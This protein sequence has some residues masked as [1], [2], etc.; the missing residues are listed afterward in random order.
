MHSARSFPRSAVAS[1]FLVAWATASR[2]DHDPVVRAQ[3]ER[4][5]TISRVSPAVVCVYDE[6]QRGGGS[7]VLIDREGHGLTN[8]HVVAGMLEKRKGWG[9]LSDG[10]LYEL[11]VLGIDPIGD[12]AMFR[13]TGRDSFPSAPL[14]DSDAVEVGDVVFAMGNPFVLSEDYTPSMSMGIV[15]GTH[16]YQYGVRG[17]LAYT[18]C[19]Q[20]DAAINPGNS[21]G[22]LFN[23][24]GEII[25][26]NGR[27]STNTR[28]RLN[29]G[30][31]YAISSNQ[32]RRFI[33]ALRAGLLARHGTL[34]G[35]VSQR[36]PGLVVFDDVTPGEAA[37][38]AGI[39]RGD[40]LVSFDGAAMVSR[41]Q[42]ASLLGT[43]PADWPIALVTEV[44]GKPRFRVVRLDAVNPQLAK[45][46]VA[47]GEINHREVRRML[48]GF[49]RAV[50]RDENAKAPRAWRW[51]ATRILDS[52]EEPARAPEV[53][54]V[55][56]DTDDAVRMTRQYG[57]GQSGP[58]VRYDE[59]SAVS[60]LTPEGGEMELSTEDRM[61]LSG[62]YVFQRRLLSELSDTDLANVA[63]GGGDAIVESL[64]RES[65]EG[66]ESGTAANDSLQSRRV[67]RS[68]LEVL[69]WPVGEQVLA[70]FD[71]DPETWRVVR[72][73]VR[74]VPTGAETTI[75]L[76][77][78]GWVA[79]IVWPSEIRVRTSSRSYREVWSDW[80]LDE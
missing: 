6:A 49:R 38:R 3:A 29:V 61:V 25:G 75:D 48:R 64:S 32:I 36:E 54:E 43:Y 69:N 17:N 71:F 13:L 35:T 40:R 78:Y 80:K 28:G 15:S 73:R 52:K 79:G 60:R 1:L 62:L 70:K 42:F 37:D 58:V 51:T 20:V 47:R 66:G 65:I 2:P 16:R 19:L 26:I 59:S 9:G 12:V 41:N 55:I 53:Y 50:L 34:G 27:I 76:M 39:R 63:C 67:N 56:S 14:G 4:I 30:H 8:Y 24:S 57:D 68:V 5:E 44:N 22:P 21:G 7:G 45:P 72:I 31:G 10:K 23:E 33:P 46:F 11:E 74:D 18:D 77:D